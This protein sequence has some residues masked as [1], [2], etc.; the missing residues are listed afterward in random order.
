MLTRS[1]LVKKNNFKFSDHYTIGAG[2]GQFSKGKNG[3]V[4]K[5]KL[6]KD[7][8]IKEVKII[9]KETLSEEELINLNK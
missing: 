9:R 7:N 6:K 5:C 1:N 3:E 4:R 2:Y 8:L